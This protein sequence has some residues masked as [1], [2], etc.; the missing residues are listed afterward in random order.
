M[1]SKKK[2]RPGQSKSNASTS[3]SRF[4]SLHSD[5]SE[6][7]TST[8]SSSGANASVS[9]MLPPPRQ[10]PTLAESLQFLRASFPHIPTDE[11]ESILIRARSDVEYAVELVLVEYAEDVE[12]SGDESDMGAESDAGW[13]YEDSVAADFDQ[14]SVSSRDTF[15][16]SDRSSSTFGTRRGRRTTTI[17]SSPPSEMDADLDGF[18]D[19]LPGS[20]F[21]STRMKE[22]GPTTLSGSDPSGSNMSFSSSPSSLSISISSSPEPISIPDV[23]GGDVDMLISIF[24]K[25]PVPEL[26]RFLSLCD[27]DVSEAVSMAMASEIEDSAPLVAPAAPEP[28]VSVKIIPPRSTRSSRSRLDACDDNLTDEVPAH[29]FLLDLLAC[30]P[31]HTP[32]TILSAIRAQGPDPDAQLVAEMLMSLEPGQIVPS[33][34]DSSAS[35]VISYRR[36]EVSKVDGDL[37]SLVEIFSEMMIEDIRDALRTHGSVAAVIEALSDTSPPP[38]DGSCITAGF[39]CLVHSS[40]RFVAVGGRKSA[41][42]VRRRV[43][44]ESSAIAGGGGWNA[45]QGSKAL[46]ASAR[47]SKAARAVVD[48]TP[49]QVYARPRA[50][51]AALSIVRTQVRSGTVGPDSTTHVDYRRRASEYRALRDAAYRKAA[52]SFRKGDLTG[53]GAAAYYAQQG[54][55]LTNKMREWNSVAAEALMERN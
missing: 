18:S 36:P 12:N 16:S 23:G 38:C 53:R 9:A 7:S 32:A 15:N 47:N 25:M 37:A 8:S 29:P 24:P 4:G 39:P 22:K 44:S 49:D 3:L 2:Q 17:S 54:A 48:G 35:T 34:F 26:E 20:P 30:F 28:T 55:N 41:G 14:A 10:G 45:V 19:R 6:E 43:Q 40:E 5:L 1:P 46:A 31:T 33:P 50:S 21:S 52:S 27:D 42:F 13:S 51:S 11:L